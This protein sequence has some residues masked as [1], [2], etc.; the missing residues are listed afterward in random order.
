MGNRFLVHDSGDAVGV[1]VEAIEPGQRAYG[2]VQDGG[3]RMEVE[4]VEAIPLGHKLALRDVEAGARVV[5][6]GVPIGVA[7]QA[8]RAGQ[9]VHTH[10]LKSAR[11]A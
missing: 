9:H 3:Q 10:N 2:V 11:W 1:A 7:T 5:E 8:I 4:V 6:Y